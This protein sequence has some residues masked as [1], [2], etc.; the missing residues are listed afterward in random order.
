VKEISTLKNPFVFSNKPEVGQS[1]QPKREKEV[2]YQE[3]MKANINVNN[4]I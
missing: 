2:I 3:I 1:P 4:V